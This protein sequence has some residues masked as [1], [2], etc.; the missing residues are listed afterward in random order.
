MRFSKI[1]FIILISY[2]SGLLVAQDLPNVKRVPAE[3]SDTSYFFPGDDSYNLCMASL[4]GEKKNVLMLVQRKAN[5]NSVV[6]EGM[7]PLM[8]AAQN[9]YLEICKLLV[10]NGA[11]IERRSLNGRSAFLLAVK[12]GNFEVSKYFIEKGAEINSRDI[13]GR[14]AL[15]YSAFAGDSA[16]CQLL[17]SNKADIAI[18]DTDKID[19]LLGATRNGRIKIVRLLLNAG[20]NINTADWQ[21]LTPV[22]VAAGTPNFEILKLLIT[23][24]AEINLKTKKNETA[25]TLAIKRHNEKVVKYLL[26]NGADVNQQLTLSENPLTVAKYYKTKDSIIFILKQNG[27]K[28]NLLPDFRN[29]TIG[30]EFNF[31][32]TDYM[33]GLSV[34]CKENKFNFDIQAGFQFRVNSNRVIGK[35]IGNTYLQLWETRYLTYLEI[36]KNFEWFFP[37]SD[38]KLGFCIGAKEIYTFGSYK[39]IVD[40]ARSAYIFSPAVGIY[41][42]FKHVQIGIYYDYVDFKTFDISPNRITIGAKIIL[43]STN[44][45]DFSF[46]KP[47]D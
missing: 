24:K 42:Y 37:E 47:W 16:I 36:L 43:G 45:L 30:P 1:K 6:D 40:P 19:A 25:L 14:T 4:R 31:N 39:G 33:N 12:S 38:D 11:T 44:K 20:A 41:N 7:T 10:E 34:G 46:Y 9:G 35:Q 28:Q 3:S 8:F 5:V 27:A 23:L 29:I 2:I 13:Y 17:I 15:I 22:M 32:T 21:G 18:K 26:E